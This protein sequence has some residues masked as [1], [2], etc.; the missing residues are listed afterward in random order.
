MLNKFFLYS[1]LYRRTE[2]K[3]TRF[4][5]KYFQHQCILDLKWRILILR[6]RKIDSE[7]EGLVA[8]TLFI[9]RLAED[10]FRCCPAGQLKKLPGMLHWAIGYA[11][12][13][14]WEALLK[15]MLSLAQASSLL[16]A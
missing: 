4:L 6:N 3:V 9:M 2:S 15:M 16:Q 14:V 12:V 13:G 7:R 1:L 10:K 5:K 8:E 11:Y